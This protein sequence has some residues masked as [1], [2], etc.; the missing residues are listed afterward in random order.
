MLV[1]LNIKG[2]NVSISVPYSCIDFVKIVFISS[3]P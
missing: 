1:P 3:F 2:P